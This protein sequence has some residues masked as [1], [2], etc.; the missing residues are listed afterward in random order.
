M[1]N[2]GRWE[3][4]DS[5]ISSYADSKLVN[6]TFSMNRA[7]E[8]GG[9]VWNAEKSN[10]TIVNCILWGNSDSGG[11]DE[12]AQIYGTG[13]RQRSQVDYCCVQGWTGS[14]GGTGNLGGNPLFVD[15]DGPDDETGTED[16]NLRLKSASP[17]INAG[18]NKAVGVDASDLD[19]DGDAN[20][21][22]PFDFEG[23]SRILNGTVDIGAF[24]S[25]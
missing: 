15:V 21:P 3:H 13:S 14:L 22:V 1:H 18:D 8:Y 19:A 7:E 17:C 2:G 12:A 23:K 16:D 9:G 10:P 11:T 24:E 4:P 20:E 5:N 25:G 6:C